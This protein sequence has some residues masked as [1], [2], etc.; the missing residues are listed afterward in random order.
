MTTTPEQ[1]YAMLL[2]ALRLVAS[3]PETQIAVLPEFVVATDEISTTFYDAFLLAPQLQRRNLINDIAYDKIR[4]LDS[5]FEGMPTDGSIVDNESLSN[6]EFW[7]TA[8]QLA[9]ESLISLG[10]EVCVPDLSHMFW[11]EGE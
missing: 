3:P 5:W 1:Q 8:R 2:E 9:K 11:T 10:E 4:R 6:H 7:N